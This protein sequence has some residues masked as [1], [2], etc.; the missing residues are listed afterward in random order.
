VSSGIARRPAH[1]CAAPIG[2]FDS[3]VGGLTVLRALADELPREHF[4]YL[5]DTARLPY[6][7]KSA[8]SIRRYAWQAASV[9]QQR[10]IKCLVV[11]CNTASAVAI[12]VL[13]EELAPVPVLGVLEPGA[14]AACAATQS[15]RIAVIATEST[16]RGGAYQA[17][18]ARRL[19]QAHVVARACP[20][21]VALA[22][23]GWTTGPV[24]DAVAHHYLDGLFAAGTP[25]MQPDTLVL[26]CTHFP[27]LAPAIR[28]V[29][30][31]GPYLVDSAATTAKALAAALATR[32]L[33]TPDGPG[34]IELLAT[35]DTDRFARVGGTFLGRPLAASDVEIVDL[36]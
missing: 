13:T 4:V 6:G 36:R 5:G 16:V 27:V 35:D 26:G 14:A 1:D 19:P 23:E 7:T 34:R 29:L 20:L 32:G 8:D 25:D 24:V 10:G 17:A 3:G 2:V 9:L 11:A 33:A 21:F 30:G 15:A 18:I 31:D 22:E 28:A 12:D